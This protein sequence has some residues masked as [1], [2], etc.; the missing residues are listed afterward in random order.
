VFT[1]FEKVS[2]FSITFI[3]CVSPDS[4][5][6]SV[7]RVLRDHHQSKSESIFKVL[8]L[9]NCVPLTITS[10]LFMRFEDISNDWKVEKV[11]YKFGIASFLRLY[12][13]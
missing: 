2:K 10:S 1:L 4:A 7:S 12:L 8:P 3:L 6:Y 11:N 13:D 9:V 5:P